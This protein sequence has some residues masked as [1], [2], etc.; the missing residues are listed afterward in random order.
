MRVLDNMKKQSQL[1][2]LI[3]LTVLLSQNLLAQV[4]LTSVPFLRIEPEARSAGLG[5]TGVSDSRNY[6]AG[7]WNPSILTHQKEY[8][9]GVTH[10]DW[11][12]GLSTDLSFDNF[13]AVIPLGPKSTLSVDALYFNLGSQSNMDASGNNLGDYSNYEFTLSSSYGYALSNHW[14]LGVNLRYISSNIAD[15]VQY[16]D[17]TLKPG[18]G[19]SYGFGTLFSKTMV[20]NS[21]TRVNTRF[22]I[23]LNNM[24]SGIDYGDNL[25]IEPLPT[26]LRIGY[27][28]DFLTGDAMKHRVSIF[29]DYSKNLARSESVE[30][31]GIT[32]YQPVSSWSA[33][34]SGWGSVDV[35]TGD[36]WVTLNFIEQ[37]SLGAGLEYALMDKF[38]LR[39][40]YYSENQWNGGRNYIT[41]GVGLNVANINTDISYLVST[42]AN[43]PMANTIRVSVRLN[44][45]KEKKQ[46]IPKYVPPVFIQPDS[47]ALEFI[48]HEVV[49]PD[50]ELDTTRIIVPTIPELTV[51]TLADSIN[52]ISREMVNFDVMSSRINPDQAA[53]LLKFVEL[54][55]TYD[56]AYI[57]IKGYTDSSG[58]LRLNT[59]LS[60]ARSR[61]VWLYMVEQGIGWQRIDI[62]GLADSD[63]L[64]DNDSDEGMAQNRRASIVLDSL[65]LATTEVLVDIT[66]QPLSNPDSRG[67]FI[68][69]NPLRFMLLDVVNENSFVTN[70]GG[71]LTWLEENPEEAIEIGYHINYPSS[72]N[73]FER[74]LE[75]ARSEK[76]KSLF[77]RSG[78]DSNR[79]EVITKAQ[80]FNWQNRM[81]GFVDF[82]QQEHLVIRVRN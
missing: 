27:S 3:V 12:P 37:W 6:Y 72:G 28:F 67:I 55:K 62:E 9:F 60:E 45:K 44:L 47:L 36:E 26:Q 38:M 73:S 33:L 56:D 68:S 4:G 7:F 65:K 64:G 10:S 2:L 46:R 1:A 75:K 25:T 22:G 19:L 15:G 30:E 77:I 23:S 11:L 32:R 5:N 41:T 63:P 79:L 80:T 51:N 78:I 59:M 74:E 39:G 29:N 58:N 70:L 17:N 71:I 57:D 8:S 82:S 81:E 54:L 48:T 52:A 14:A 40:G 34:T 76:I 21:N 69:G 18:T 43:D 49:V 20:S 50:I 53:V 24:G 66:G 35:Y 61:A 13:S 42:K 31:N 16:Q